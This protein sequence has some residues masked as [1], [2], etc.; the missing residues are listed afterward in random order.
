MKAYQLRT[1]CS[2]S[3]RAMHILRSLPAPYRSTSR[4]DIHRVARRPIDL[5]VVYRREGA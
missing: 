2:N 4:R 1:L 3:V 5:R